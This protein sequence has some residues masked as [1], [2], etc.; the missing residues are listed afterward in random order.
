MP[1]LTP[2]LA[3]FMTYGGF[4]V[5]DW[6]RNRCSCRNSFIS[7]R[8]IPRQLLRT[9]SRIRTYSAFLPSVEVS[10]VS[11]FLGSAICSEIR[12]VAHVVIQPL[13]SEVVRL[14]GTMASVDSLQTGCSAALS[15]FSRG[16][17]DKARSFHSVQA[18]FAVS[19]LDRVSGV[20]IH[21]CLTS[22]AL[23]F[24]SLLVRPVCVLPQSSFP[25]HSLVI[26]YY[27]SHS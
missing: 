22:Y 3:P 18:E 25:P 17:Q 6:F 13:P 16:S 20:S 15:R 23:A 4:S 9:A 5:C 26:F 8:Q 19:T 1:P 10:Y 12:V 24:Y 7:P 14:G 27:F 11:V 21:C 2:P